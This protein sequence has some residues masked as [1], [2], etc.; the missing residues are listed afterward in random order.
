MAKPVETTEKV[1]KKVRACTRHKFEFRVMSSF[2]EEDYYA[3]RAEYVCTKCAKVDYCHPNREDWEAESLRRKCHVCGLSHLHMQDNTCINFMAGRIT[4]LEDKIK[5]IERRL[6]N[7][8]LR[9]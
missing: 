2:H 3:S 1:T 4:E 8:S 7:A 9:F 5:D 6:E